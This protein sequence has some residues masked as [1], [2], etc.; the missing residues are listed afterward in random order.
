MLTHRPVSS[1]SP[2]RRARILEL[3]S[4]SRPLAHVDLRRPA[5][6]L[7]VP[8]HLCVSLPATRGKLFLTDTLTRTQTPSFSSACSS[9]RRCSG[10]GR[11]SAA[12]GSSACSRAST[13]KASRRPTGCVYLPKKK[14]F[15]PLTLCSSQ[16][17]PS[18]FGDES[19]A[20]I[21]S[22]KAF[23]GQPRFSLCRAELQFSR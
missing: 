7:R 9:S 6:E 22:A 20:T 16:L 3:R 5:L 21:I 14:G 12:R 18:I 19:N 11:T 17:D 1:Q 10:S 4:Q 13:R 2:L 23:L 15:S 8:R